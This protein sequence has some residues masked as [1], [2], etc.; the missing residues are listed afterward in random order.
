[1]LYGLALVVAAHC[2]W[3]VFPLYF[4]ALGDIPP[5]EVL[6]H[7]IVWS[8]VFAAIII[9]VT[10][11]T[12]WIG[13]LLK[14]PKTIAFFLLSA[15][16]IAVNWGTYIYATTSGH[17]ISASLG[18]FINPLV[19]V[20]LGTIFLHERLRPVQWLSVAL[21]ACGVIYLT[22]SQGELP[23]ISLILPISFALYG[24][25][26]KVAPLGSLE[27]FT[28]ESALLTPFALVYLGY[29]ASLD[30]LFFAYGPVNTDLL[31]IAAGPMTAI[32]LLL[33]AA[34]ARKLPYSVLGIA[35]YT[36]PT[37]QFILALTVFKETIS[38]EQIITF[39][40]IWTAVLLFTLESILYYRRIKLATN[41]RAGVK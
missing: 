6:A 7:R 11:R 35:Q 16:L 3:G 18:Y 38:M 39:T 1:M 12:Q 32:P 29:L 21:V 25:V 41:A 34:A 4:N 17:N 31:L 20:F 13:Q 14:T 10:R 40:M 23:I 27:G 19:N 5:L 33:F 36:S 30:Q 15:L 24:L 8:V 37:I 2:L 28:L 22:V 9:T 26:R